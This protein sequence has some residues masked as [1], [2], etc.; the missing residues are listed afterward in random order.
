MSSWRNRRPPVYGLSYRVRTDAE[1]HPLF[2][3]NLK[4]LQD[5]WIHEYPV[6]SKLE[7]QILACLST[8][9]GISVAQLLDAFSELLVDVIWALLTRNRVFTNLEA[10][11]LMQWDQVILYRSAEEAEHEARQVTVQAAPLP[12]FLRICF[13][14]RLWEVEKQGEMVLLRPEIGAD[15]TLPAHTLQHL[16]TTGQAVEARDEAPSALITTGPCLRALP[17]A[18]IRLLIRLRMPRFSICSGLS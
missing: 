18:V 5:F 16:L 17:I 10:S 12:L 4:S 6:A 2:I 9:P 3:Q 15:L 13:D 7:E 11:S 1:L 14:G 8:S